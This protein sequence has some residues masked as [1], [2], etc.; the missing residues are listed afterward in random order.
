MKILIDVNHPAH[1]HYFKNLIWIL[2]N[3]GHEILVISREKEVTIDL[4]EKYQFR[5]LNRGKGRKNVIGKLIYLIS[6]V[7]FDYRQAKKFKPDLFLSFGSMYAAQ[8]AKLIGKPHIALDD[9]EHAK[10]QQLLTNPFCD[11]ILT[12]FC[13][14]ADFG[15]KQIRFNSFM[16]LAYLHPKYFSPNQDIYQLLKIETNQKYA[17][18]RFVS[19]DASHDIGQS[20]LTFKLKN[21]I[22]TLLSKTMTV[23]IS[24]ERKL[25]DELKKYEIHIPPDRMHDVLSFAE[26]YIGEGATMASECVML[27]TPAFYINSLNA[28]TLIEQEKYGLLFSFRNTDGIISQLKDFMT[29][30]TIKDTFQ[31]RR[32]KMLE[33]MIDLTAFLVWF[34][35]NYPKSKEKL[36]NNPDFQSTFK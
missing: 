22:I 20:G 6:A 23:F 21:E 10:F 33:D 2:T 9:T 15:K 14:Q 27:G 1:I 13:F 30:E 35:E 12:P 28:G 17:L 3:N 16:E 5:Y 32:L 26:V 8:A 11:V 36:K 25:P 4:L 34:I 18:L 19:W 24:S 31:I 29:K 7:A